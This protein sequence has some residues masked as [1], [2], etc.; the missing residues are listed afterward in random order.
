MKKT[1]LFLLI[2]VTFKHAYAQNYALISPTQE[3]HFR[4]VNNYNIGSLTTIESIR[5]DSTNHLGNHTFYRNHQVLTQTSYTGSCQIMVHDSS[6]VGH[7]I[8][9]YPNGDYLFFNRHNDSILIKTMAN[10][11]DTWRLYTFPNQDYIEAKVVGVVNSSILGTMDSVKTIQLQVKNSSNNNINNPFNQKEIKFSKNYGLVS[12]YAMPNFPLDTNSYH[13]VGSSAPD[14]GTVNVTASD[15][16]NY[17]IGDIFHIKDY[18]QSSSAPWEYNY[19]NIRKVV[20][21][22]VVSNNQDTLT[23]TMARCQ[24]RY[25]SQSMSATPDTTITV[26]TIVETIILS[27]HTYLNQLSNEIRSDSMSYSTF[28]IDPP[29]NRR[30]KRVDKQYYR[31]GPNCWSELIGS[32]ATYHTYIEGLGGGYFV[33]YGTVL[34]VQKYELVY[35]SKSGTT[36]GTPLNIDCTVNTSTSKLA[37]SSNDILVYPVPTSDKVTIE[38]QNF[39][40]YKNWSLELYDTTGKMLRSNSI[41]SRSIVLQKLDLPNGIYFYKIQN[42][43]TAHS[44]T[45]KLI[46][47]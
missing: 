21:D 24:N 20:L 26:D 18:Y 27:E 38:I 44:Y 6:W 15:I 47:R 45:G 9:A 30:S 19:K 13:L 37:A 14:L 1:F 36:W 28:L 11:N 34:G 10:T 12:F 46:F 17:D 33:N 7:Q 8:L 22:K 16:F 43:D 25:H 40:Q 31:V 23:Y 41:T 2:L 3:K 5:I 29:T 39:S 42:E 4:H 32:F 35:F